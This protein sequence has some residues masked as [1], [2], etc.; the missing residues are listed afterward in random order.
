MKILIYLVIYLTIVCQVLSENS[1]WI[2]HSDY[3]SQKLIF[4][5]LISIS[6]DLE[7][8]KFYTF[9]KNN[10]VY[11]WDYNTGI[12]LDSIS[13]EINPIL[14]KFSED[15]KSLI[16]IQNHQLDKNLRE[17]Y[18]FKIINLDTKSII[19]SFI[20]QIPGSINCCNPYINSAEEFSF[21]SID[22]DIQRN[23][24]IINIGFKTKKY[25]SGI[26]VSSTT[27]GSCGGSGIY[28]VKK[29]SVV[30][31]EQPSLLPTYDIININN[32]LF[33][34]IV[35]ITGFES[36][37][38]SMNA[39]NEKY[40]YSVK[41]INPVSLGTVISRTFEHSSSWVTG[42]KSSKDTN[43]IKV[44]FKDLYYDK[45][46]D[47]LIVNYG[48]KSF[49]I[50]YDSEVVT[51]SIDI[52]NSKANILMSTNF[53]YFI[54]FN[55]DS[56][57]FQNSI[58]RQIDST[59]ACPIIP[60]FLLNGVGKG[61]LIAANYNGQIILFENITTNIAKKNVIDKNLSLSP[62][63]ATDYINIQLSNKVLQPF[64]SADKIQIFDMLGIEVLN[65]SIPTMTSSH[66]MNIEKLPSGVYFIR[67]GAK[68]E[69][70]LKM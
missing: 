3:K 33:A 10:K 27:I 2:Q 26:P 19:S 31:I 65:E 34:S 22:Y 41:K 52:N 69:K 12:L 36:S 70:F 56:I 5:D 23:E 30:V 32:K 51:D 29:D 44:P 60:D 16:I 28:S 7:I 48:K 58:T 45:T 62:N 66:R 20:F 13:M 50:N 6:I 39:K 14:I 63:P 42:G 4:S 40:V 53:D 43:G 37:S 38:A 35:D 15:S 55:N 1:G 57:Y 9:N 8:S 17:N 25:S 11:Y 24:F 54:Y 49:F 64:A 18:S 46:N 59:I 61:S 67:I 68:V 21:N 47:R